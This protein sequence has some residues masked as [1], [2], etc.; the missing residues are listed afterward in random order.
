MTRP[1]PAPAPSGGGMRGSVFGGGGGGGGGLA[2]GGASTKL[3]D[4]TGAL[5]D[6]TATPNMELARVTS[7]ESST[8]RACTPAESVSEVVEMLAAICTDAALTVSVT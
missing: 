5:A 3:I 7:L 2:G 1:R 4:T 8:M 6:C